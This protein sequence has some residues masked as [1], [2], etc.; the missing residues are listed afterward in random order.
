[1]QQIAKFFQEAYNELRLSTWLSFN[2][3]V[4]ST[5]IVVVLTVLIS[6]YVAG[7]DRLLLAIV[8]LLFRI[9]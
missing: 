2:E 4:H 6:L 9:G 5:A 8:H 7:V 3:M 1:M